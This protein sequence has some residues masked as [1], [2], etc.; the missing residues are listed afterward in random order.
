MDQMKKGYSELNGIKLYYEIYGHGEPL[1]LL[2]GGG[3]TIG[4]SFGRMIPL[5]EK[6][7]LLI[8]V[9]LQNH[10]R[11]GHRDIP[12]T[13]EQDADDVAALLKN[14]TINKASIFGFSNG[15]TTAIQIGIRHPQIV[16]KLVLAAAASKRSGFINGFFEMMPNATLDNMPQPLKEAFLEVNPDQGKLQHMFECDRDRMINFTD[17]NDELVGS[18]T[19]PALIINGDKDVIT[20]EHSLEMHRLLQNSRL[21]IIPGIHGAYIGEITTGAKNDRDIEF[22]ASLV[23]EFLEQE[24]T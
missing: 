15:A 24:A 1:V 23:K 13:F 16:R 17:I 18:V 11:S 19:A 5:L 3:S 8:A 4:C 22:T 6:H 12:E 10:G 9:E 20:V 7:F 14:L 21:A 2:H